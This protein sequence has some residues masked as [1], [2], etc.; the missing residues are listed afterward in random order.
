MK[1]TDGRSSRIAMRSPGGGQTSISVDV[2]DD[3]GSIDL[4]F[5]RSSGGEVLIRLNRGTAA[6]LAAAI[7]K[8]LVPT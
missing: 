7:T 8:A 6:S 3:D 4:M 5:A 1:M 2:A